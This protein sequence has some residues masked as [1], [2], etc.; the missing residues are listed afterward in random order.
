[1]PC[2][3]P[4]IPLTVSF[5][6]KQST[7]RAVGIRKAL[8]YGLSIVIIYVALGLGITILLGASAL[9]ELSSDAIFNLIFFLVLVIFATSF[10]GAFEIT[11]P[12]SWSTKAD[13]KAD[14]GGL[15]GIF[16]MA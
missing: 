10:F 12:S 13:A 2:I 9:N 15:L 14:K 1:M 6:T 3:F 16:F 4:M 8:I 5:F 7:S 11:L